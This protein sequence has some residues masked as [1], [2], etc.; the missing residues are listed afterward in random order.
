MANGLPVLTT[1]NSQGPD[2]IECG[3]NGWILPIR[4][5]EAFIEQLMWCDNHRVELANLI[6]V[7]Y[8]RK[9]IRTFDDVAKDL[10]K[11]AIRFNI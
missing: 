2:V 9:K 7:S 5:A 10:E 8:E 1:T 11:L 4:N 3:Q 6:R